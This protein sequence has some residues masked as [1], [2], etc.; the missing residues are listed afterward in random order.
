M[1]ISYVP[2]ITY[3]DIFQRGCSI[4]FESSN[5]DRP[6]LQVVTGYSP[7]WERKLKADAIPTLNLFSESQVVTDLHGT[8]KLDDIQM[9]TPNAER[10]HNIQLDILDDTAN[11]ALPATLIIE[12]EDIA[13]PMNTNPANVVLENTTND[14]SSAAFVNSTIV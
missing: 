14:S 8:T 1:Y 5:F 3:I 6:V 2:H 4:H 7:S 13:Q 12:P 9:A 10:A 11:M